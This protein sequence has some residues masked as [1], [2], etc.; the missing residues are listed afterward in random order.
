[1]YRKIT[2]KL[3][4]WQTSSIRKPLILQGARQVGK[5]YVAN[6]FWKKYYENVVYC[7]LESDEN[8]KS[9]FETLEPK[10]IIGKISNLK[11]QDIFK[12]K[13]LIIFD[14]V[15]SLKGAIT[16]L[17]YFCEMASEYHIIS[18]GS[19]LGVAVNRDTYSYPVGK[20]DT[21]E[22]NPL[23]FEEFLIANNKSDLLEKIYNCY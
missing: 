3:K 14:E 9:C 12:E 21:M 23:D 19:L 7:Q 1:M 4:D 11:K 5:T 8:V 20:V 16:S 10:E 2:E 18:L 17:K 13:T 6:E 22:L 15:Q